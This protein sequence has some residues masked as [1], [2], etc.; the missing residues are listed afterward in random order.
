MVGLIFKW[1]QFFI[2]PYI[3]ALCTETLQVFPQKA[4]LETHLGQEKAIKVGIVNSEP[5]FQEAMITSLSQTPASCTSQVSLQE[6]LCRE[7]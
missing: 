3:H 2:L 1:L 7:G 4:G 6:S 5:L